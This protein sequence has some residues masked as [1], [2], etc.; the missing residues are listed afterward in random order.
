MIAPEDHGCSHHQEGPEE[1]KRAAGKDV[2]CIAPVDVA[3]GMLIEAT[4]DTM[5]VH[6]LV[7]T[8][9]AVSLMSSALAQ[10]LGVLP[11]DLGEVSP[12]IRFCGA[13]GQ[14][15]DVVGSVVVELVIRSARCLHE[16]HVVRQ[17][18]HPCIIGRDVLA[19][20]PCEIV[21]KD[22]TLSFEAHQADVV[23]VP[24]DVSVA[25]RLRRMERIPAHSEIVV[26]AVAADDMEVGS[27]WLVAPIDQAGWAKHGHPLSTVVSVSEE[28][29][30]VCVANWSG[31]DHFLPCGM[32]VGRLMSVNAVLD[33]TQLGKEPCDIT[34][35]WDED[36][37][38]KRCYCPAD[39]DPWSVLQ[40][41][42]PGRDLLEYGSVANEWN[43]EHTH[44]L[45][46]D[47]AEKRRD[48]S[49]GEESSTIQASALTDELRELRH[50]V[51]KHRKA[52]AMN[53]KELGRT[54]VMDHKIDTGDAHPIFQPARRLAWSSRATARDL[55]E[56]MLSKGVV[57]ESSSPWSAPIVLVTKKDGSTRFCVDYR[58]LN[59]ITVKDPY[60]LPRI[61]DTLDA[62]GGARYFSTLDLCSGYHQ[63]PMARDDKE[64]TAFSTPD[65]HYQFTVMPFGVCNGPSSFQRLMGIVLKGLQWHGCLVYLDDIIVYGRTFQEHLERLAAVFERLERAG[66]RLKPSKCHLLRRNVE[67]LGHVVSAEGIST[68]PAKIERVKD[69]P[70]PTNV[71]DVRSFLG[72]AGYYRRFVK[73]FSTT[74]KPLTDLLRD[75]TPFV[76]TGNCQQS[77]RQLCAQLTD[78]PVLAYPRFGPD[79]PRFIIDVD[80]SGVGLGAVLSQ[81]GEDGRE[82]PIAYASRLISRT[83]KNYGSTK[84]EFLGVVWAFRHFRCYLLG[85]RFL[86]RTDHKALK[87]WQKFKDPSAIIARWMEFLSQFEFD[88]QYRQGR[89]HANAD[90]L[91]RQ[92]SAP[93][94]ETLTNWMICMRCIVSYLG[95]SP[96]RMLT[97]LHHAPCQLLRTTHCLCLHLSYS[98]QIGQ[99]TH[100]VMRNKKTR[101][102][103]FFGHGWIC[104][105]HSHFLDLLGL[106][107]HYI[108][109]GGDANAF[110]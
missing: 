49:I 15:L 40:V 105:H 98:V 34:G 52:F 10:Q 68:D 32:E 108:N 43:S 95:Q 103:Y 35:G 70:V 46:H 12:S 26:W 72:F 62:L 66:L 14:P 54:S 48:G 67:F 50:V 4:V 75:G 8:G 89:A 104:I 93:A 33:A 85:K 7:D 5:P 77:F 59:A 11:E 71:G 38:A 2:E 18:R 106:A 36:T 20:I 102:C 53:S 73:D 101:N 109:I 81:E 58:K 88:V 90:G 16:M 57:E 78:A 84:S 41:G 61:D 91:S 31:E 82:R 76:W 55:V 86:V 80:A 1:S 110:V 27:P 107:P 97:T 28:G 64:K 17:L 30:P 51:H 65:G 6:V 94:P 47:V 42:D 29:V 13:G 39:Q 56:D 74:A 21:S 25:L 9:A 24:H 100:G 92:G 69:W 37:D 63:L 60:P 3:N 44:A 79:A 23:T 45:T 87:Y 99:W 83:E 19:Q 96:A 22:G